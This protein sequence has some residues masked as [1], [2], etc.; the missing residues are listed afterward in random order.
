MFAIVLHHFAFP[1]LTHKSSNF[2]I[3][4]PTFTVSCLLGDFFVFE[5]SHLNGCKVLSRCGFDLHFLNDYY[6][7]PVVSCV[8]LFVIPWTTAHQAP[9]SMGFP[10]QEYW[11]GLPFP[12]PGHL[13]DPGTESPSHALQVDS[14]PHELY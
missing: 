2:P 6:L 3:S 7:H 4:L 12:S 9:L 1:Q 5:S 10:R 8:R 13:P 14:L 11:S